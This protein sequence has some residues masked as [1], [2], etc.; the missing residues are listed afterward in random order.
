MSQD[1]K[2]VPFWGRALQNSQT[3]ERWFFSAWRTIVVGLYA[4]SS[5]L[6]GKSQVNFGKKWI[7]VYQLNRLFEKDTLD[8]RNNLPIISLIGLLFHSQPT[9]LKITYRT[10]GKD[11][12]GVACSSGTP[13]QRSFI[14]T[15]HPKA[16]RRLTKRLTVCSRSR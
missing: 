14:L 5:G 15:S 2:S 1:P 16:S 3:Y 4:Y 11:E 8:H 9:A 6:R 13:F 10:S 7:F 12:P